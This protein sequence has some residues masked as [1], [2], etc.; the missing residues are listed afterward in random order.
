[1]E[2][3]RA[4]AAAKHGEIWV[5]CS[6]IILTHPFVSCP[7]VSFW[8]YLR[9]SDTS[10]AYFWLHVFRG[11]Y[12]HEYTTADVDDN[13][14]PPAHAIEYFRR[15]RHTNQR[16]EWD[17]PAVAA[18]NAIETTVDMAQAAANQAADGGSFAAKA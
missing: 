12:Q 2:I 10:C 4:G 3:G 15:N 16:V 5:A 9:N 6:H 17:E 13:N 7:C 11:Q 1:M 8:R 18:L 14:Q